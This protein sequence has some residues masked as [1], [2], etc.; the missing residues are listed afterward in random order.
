MVCPLPN[1]RGSEWGSLLLWWREWGRRLRCGLE[2][3]FRRLRKVF[4]AT[5]LAVNWMV[6]IY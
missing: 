6:K 1:G 2:E 3:R 5:N 4:T